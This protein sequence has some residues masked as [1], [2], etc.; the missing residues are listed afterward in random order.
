MNKDALC[1]NC[2]TSFNTHC[3]QDPNAVHTKTLPCGHQGC[4]EKGTT[5]KTCFFCSTT[6]TILP[7]GHF[8]ARPVKEFVKQDFNCT[9][10]GKETGSAWMGHLYDA[11]R[12]YA[13][14]YCET[15]K[16]YY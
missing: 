6:F 5:T 15:C 11:N 16:R 7:C 4:I 13:T 1:Y 14:V 12:K 2:E 8:E 9:N 3:V 10:C